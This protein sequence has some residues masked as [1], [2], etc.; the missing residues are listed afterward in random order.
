MESR[1]LLSQLAASP[2]AATPVAEPAQAVP[3]LVPPLGPG[4]GQP[5]PNELARER[6][7]ASFS[8]PF[9]VGPPRFTDQSKI[10]YVRGLGGSNQ[11]LHGDFQMG[12]VFPADPTA[13]ITGVIY[14]QDKNMNGGA[15]LAFDL[16][17]DPKS[18]D[19]LGRPTLA[20]FVNDPNV[21][22]G[23]YFV[24]TASGTLRIG[25]HGKAATVIIDGR[26]YTG[27]LTNV[28]R[29]QD[30]TARGGRLFSRA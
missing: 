21:Y 6:F 18:L 29:N 17:F 4:T 23:T 12:I 16:T 22:S 14:M 24:Q 9:Y 13:P 28:L 30:L 2:A 10:L 20:T 3:G 27:G 1:E 7:H 25:Y 15:S 11:F 5:L 26:V 19:R 8:G